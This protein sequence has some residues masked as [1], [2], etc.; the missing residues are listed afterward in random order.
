MK[1]IFTTSFFAFLLVFLMSPALYGQQFYIGFDAGYGLKI[2]SPEG[3]WDSDNID[4]TETTITS[5]SVPYSL[6]QGFQTGLSVGYMFNENMGVEL[7]LAYM[8]GAPVKTHYLEN[9]DYHSFNSYDS[10]SAQSFRGS[11]AFII[12]LRP[13]ATF[14]PFMKTGLICSKAGMEISRYSEHST[15][16][17]KFSQGINLGVLSSLG[18]AYHMNDKLALVAEF[19]IQLLNY[20]PGKSVI[21]EHTI[22]GVDQ[23]PDMTTS[24]KEVEYVNSFTTNS[25]MTQPTNEPIKRYKE[26][27]PLSSYGLYIGLRFNL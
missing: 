14:S 17:Y 21:T 9:D 3:L 1:N 23:L 11:P 7:G 10:Q 26:L 20:T 2:N 16:T 4:I 27:Y 15:I 5:Q 25:I 19:K 18:A 6:G 8:N 13:D 12:Q 22:N 24:Q